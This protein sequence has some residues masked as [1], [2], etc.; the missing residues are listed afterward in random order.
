MDI[1]YCKEDS[2]LITKYCTKYS[3]KGEKCNEDFSSISSSKSI[4][5]KLWAYALKALDHRECGAIEAAD[6]LL[7]NPLYGTDPKTVFRWVDVDMVRNVKVKPF[8]EIKKLPDDSEN[9]Y[10]ENLVNDHYPNRP[11][12]LESVCLYDI[13]KWWE[14][15][16]TEPKYK[17]VYHKGN[18]ELF[19]KQRKNPYLVNYYKN[20]VDTNPE[21][22][23]YAFLLL[24]KPWRDCSTLI[25]EG[26]T[27]SEAFNKVKE[28]LA[29]AMQHHE[30]YEMIKKASERVEKM[31]A[32]EMEKNSTVDSDN[33]FDNNDAT[34]EDLAI[35]M[36]AEIN[37]IK[38]IAAKLI[39]EKDLSQMIS[40]FNEDQARIFHKV[41]SNILD[42]SK[43]TRMFISGSGG[44]G[45]SYLINLLVMWNKQIRGKDTAVTAPT[46]LAAFNVNGITIHKLLQLPV[47]QGGTP[48]YMDLFDAALKSIRS[49]IKDIDLLII[50]EIS[51]VSNLHLLYIHMR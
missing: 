21:G 5:S 16:K 42:G 45:K 40:Q 35:D 34:L 9:I 18:N 8:E 33:E 1:Q 27:Y 50:D 6:T 28:E 7:G 10:Y 32:E 38:E 30:K 26:K 36:V 51:M 23:Y 2:Y 4:S 29:I 22:Y 47:E 15:V 20:N 48:P 25:G 3:T 11:K 41:T 44:T 17:C 31:V 24:F 46:G 37:L 13:A 14:I 49:Y 19:Y 43:K 12:E 39:N